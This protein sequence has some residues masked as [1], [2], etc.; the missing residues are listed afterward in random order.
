MSTPPTAAGSATP[1]PSGP[2]NPS[3]TA[4]LT[5]LTTHLHRLADRIEDLDTRCRENTDTLTDKVIPGLAQVH[6]QTTAQL[7]AHHEQVQHLLDTTHQAPPS[8][9]SN[10]D[11]E[12]ARATWE[13]LATWI[14]DTL[15]PWYE[16]TRDQLPDCWAHH[17]PAVVQLTWLHHT[18]QAAHQPNAEPH[19]TAEWHTRW[20]PAVLHALENAVPRNGRRTCGPGHHLTTADDQLRPHPHQPIPIPAEPI[21]V[22][23]DQLAHR[24]HWQHFYD[25]ALTADLTHR[26]RHT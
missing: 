9:W 21:E 18:F 4:E 14:A 1:P 5:A 6:A 12:Q 7:A 2:H 10:M 23:T 20:L 22:P 16:I 3:P 8:D 15:V 24:H 25:Q 11:V 13:S 26:P 17:R 19:L